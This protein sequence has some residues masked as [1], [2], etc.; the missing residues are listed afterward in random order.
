MA[1]LTGTADGSPP[2]ERSPLERGPFAPPERT[3]VDIFRATVAAHPDDPAVDDGHVV[4]TYAQLLHRVEE[5]AARLDRA[6]VRRGD[7]VGIRMPSGS[8]D[9]YVAVLGTLAAGA[10][11]VPV[12][13]DDPRERA[14]LVFRTAA[15]HGCP[16]RRAGPPAHR[17]G[18]ASRPSATA[19]RHRRSMTMR[20]SSS[21]RD[22]RVRRKALR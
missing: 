1:E 17:P 13:A 12:D 14:N 19:S 2:R 11:Y 9:L 10:A 16:R 18:V 4:L 5:V 22:R 3:L 21:P 20:G 8:A 15:G 6:G 7:R